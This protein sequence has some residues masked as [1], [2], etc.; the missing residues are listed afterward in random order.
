[1]LTVIE[2]VGTRHSKNTLLELR[3]MSVG[4]RATKTGSHPG[5]LLVWRA[6]LSLLAVFSAAIFQGPSAE[7][8]ESVRQQ[9]NS[10]QNVNAESAY[11]EDTPKQLVKHV[12][13]LK[14]MHPATDQEA[15]PTILKKTAERV[16]EFLDNVVD[17]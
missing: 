14:G 6:L 5:R 9:D 12:P 17:L 10:E 11:L 16:D 4:N 15:L 1:M 2:R 7:G 13:E 3:N 8:S